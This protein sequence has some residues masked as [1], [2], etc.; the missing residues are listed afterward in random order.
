MGNKA[1]TL[2]GIRGFGCFELILKTSV[3][4]ANYLT[5]LRSAG[6]AVVELARLIANGVE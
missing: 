6:T 3:W 1:A 2:E 5:R 4:V